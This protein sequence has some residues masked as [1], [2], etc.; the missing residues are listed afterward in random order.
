[1]PETTADVPNRIVMSALGLFV[2]LFYGLIDVWYDKGLPLAAFLGYAGFWTI[3][4]LAIAFAPFQR[5]KLAAV[6][7]FVVLLTLLWAVPWMPRKRFLQHYW[8]IRPGMNVAQVEA[9]MKPFADIGPAQ[10]ARPI[11]PEFNGTLYY[12]H[13]Q[14]DW[15]YNA[16]IARVTF[17]NGKVREVSFSPD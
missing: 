6:P 13:T 8:R 17:R 14:D 15:R 12:H 10:P 7:V 1:M 9:H 4:L 5:R 11:P 2:L 16:D 3:V